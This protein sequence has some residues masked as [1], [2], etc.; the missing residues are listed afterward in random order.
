ME[1]SVEYGLGRIQRHASGFLSW[2]FGELKA[3]LP[4]RLT[5]LLS[6]PVNEL[7]LELTARRLLLRHRD[8]GT[9]RELGAVQV[10]G[11]DPEA[12]KLALRPL[13]ADLD[14]R[15]VMVSLRLPAE[16]ALRKLVDLP[17][18]AEENLRQVLAFEMDRLT[19]F[20]SDAVHYDV[21]VIDRNLENR[22]I[23]VELMVLPR[24]V[25]DPT[26]QL[27]HRLGLEPDVVALARGADERAPWQLP[28]ASNGSGER[29]FVNRVSVAL[30]ALAGALLVAAVYTAFDRQR[31]RAELLARDIDMAR[32]EAEEGRLLQERIEQLSAEGSFIVDKKRARPPV[33]QVLNELTRAL[34]DDTWLYRLR[35]I[36]EELQTFGYS[37]NASAMIG[38]IENSTLFSNAQFRAPLTRDQRVDAEQFHIAF[39][40]AMEKAQ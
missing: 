21:R 2:W 20:P 10:E 36:N 35:L 37:P 16:L 3:L 9:E 4:S 38:H 33:V 30:L 14:L 5:R 7:A 19:P 27:L 25:V 39:Q 32:K 12:A 15:R 34:P 18:A 17:A 6:P 1:R 29:R 23:R 13:I 40:V 8:G 28:L 26:I 31:A 24:A 11:V 22:R